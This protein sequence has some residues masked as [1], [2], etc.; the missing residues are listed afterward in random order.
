MKTLRKFSAEQSD[1]TYN[2]RDDQ[3]RSKDVLVCGEPG[4]GINCRTQE[5][6]G[7]VGGHDARGYVGS[8]T[9]LKVGLRLSRRRGGNCRH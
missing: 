7:V 3:Q 8:K 6:S 9:L 4:L 1:G 5:W 2:D